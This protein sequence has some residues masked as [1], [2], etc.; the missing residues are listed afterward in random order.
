MINGNLGS[1]YLQRRME[2]AIG[3]SD[4]SFRWFYIIWCIPYIQKWGAVWS[5]ESVSQLSHI[6]LNEVET[7][8]QC[9]FRNDK[10]IFRR[11]NGSYIVKHLE[12][13]PQKFL[14]S[15]KVWHDWFWWGKLR[16]FEGILGISLNLLMKRALC[17]QSSALRK[18][19]PW[20][21]SS[22]ILTNQKSFNFSLSSDSEIAAWHALALAN[23]NFDWA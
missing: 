10:D 1:C 5:C 13:S 23:K 15:L 11:E 7:S 4:W 3:G 16:F 6:L 2:G 19:W 21:F 12:I 18:N 14:W 20:K 9:G 22:N 8:Q 17:Q